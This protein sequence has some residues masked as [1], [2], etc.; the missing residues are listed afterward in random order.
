[1]VLTK[2]FPSETFARALESWS[3]LDLAGKVPVLASMFG[4]V[5]LQDPTGYWFL[6]SIEGSLSKV[7]ADR[8]ELQSILDTTDGQDK[9]LLG[10]LALAAERRG[11]VPKEDEIY[12]FLVPPVLGGKF[13]GANITVRDFVVALDISGQIHNQ[14]RD[15][16][17]GTKIDGFTVDG[18]KP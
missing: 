18:F 1:M 17:P 14:I 9:Y 3:W 15:L 11:L 16:P 7:A 12:D 4:D 2:R 8:A 13:D 10:G 6:D 5:F